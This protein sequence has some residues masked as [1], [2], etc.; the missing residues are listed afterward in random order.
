M[1]LLTAAR[2]ELPMTQSSLPLRWLG[3]SVTLRRSLLAFT[4]V[5]CAF[6]LTACG[7][8]DYGASFGYPSQPPAPPG[9][10]VIVKATGS[11]DDD[12]MRGREVVIERTT[13]SQ[14]DLVTYYRDQFPSDAGWLE[15][16]PDVDVGGDH[17]LCLVNHSADD[18]DEYVEIYPYDDHFKSAG[19]DRYLVQVS[20]LNVASDGEHTVDRCGVAGGW[21]PMDL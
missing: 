14:S 20:R 5:A 18:F 10:S 12:P 19:A 4:F 21:F 15:G 2:T 17:L 3:T 8:L 1:R 16:A 13:A 11:D 9:T 7:M 6:V